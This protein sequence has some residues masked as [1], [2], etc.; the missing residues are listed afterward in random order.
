MR[1]EEGKGGRSKGG[2]ERRITSA[3]LCNEKRKYCI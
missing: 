2:G 3:V 1:E